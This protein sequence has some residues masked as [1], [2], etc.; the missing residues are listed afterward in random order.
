MKVS[1]PPVMTAPDCHI[2]LYWNDTECCRHAVEK[3][4]RQHVTQQ[5]TL[6]S[7]LFWDVDNTHTLC[8]EDIHQTTH[9]RTACHT[10]LL[11]A[12]LL[13]QC[14]LVLDPVCLAIR[15]L[16]VLISSAKPTASPTALQLLTHSTYTLSCTSLCHLNTFYLY[17]CVAAEMFL[18][19]L[20]PL[21]ISCLCCSAL[22][23]FVLLLL[24][25]S[26]Y[27]FLIWTM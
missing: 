5:E 25:F 9:I 17:L 14:L 19:D 4:Y 11:R 6:P 20:I 13:S 10:I 21:I 16:S 22:L 23:H 7:P 3:L 24:L 2:S 27:S 8:S 15:Q 18:S 1:L 12:N 26:K